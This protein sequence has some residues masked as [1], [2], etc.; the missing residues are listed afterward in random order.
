MKDKREAEDAD[1]KAVD[2]SERGNVTTMKREKQ[3]SSLEKARAEEHVRARE[4]E[5]GRG[6][7]RKISGRCG[8]YTYRKTLKRSERVTKDGSNGAVEC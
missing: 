3:R 7:R 6:R 5:K 4:R 1:G 8:I 2:E